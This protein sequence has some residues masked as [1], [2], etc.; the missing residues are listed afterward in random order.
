MA[1]VRAAARV[2]DAVA[3]LAVAEARRGVCG[4]PL[5]VARVSVMRLRS[6]SSHERGYD[7][8]LL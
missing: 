6:V 8:L 2:H 7:K 5:R 3:P 1:A 4:R